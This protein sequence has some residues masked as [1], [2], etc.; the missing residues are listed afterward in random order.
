MESTKEPS[1]RIKQKKRIFI[2]MK[3][4][5]N[6]INIDIN[7][8]GEPSNDAICADDDLIESSSFIIL[9]TCI[10]FDCNCI[11][12]TLNLYLISCHLYFHFAVS[13]SL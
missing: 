3:H 11:C 13:F 4:V 12:N 1:M 9:L 2:K 10:A 5:R 8:K 6:I 7:T